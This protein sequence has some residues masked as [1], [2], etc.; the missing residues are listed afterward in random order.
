MFNRQHLA[1]Y[2]LGICARDYSDYKNHSFLRIF[3]GLFTIDYQLI[4]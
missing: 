2:P 4:D 1:S 3:R